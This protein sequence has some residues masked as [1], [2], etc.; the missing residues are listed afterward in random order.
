[1]SGLKRFTGG[2]VERAGPAGPR[3]GCGG[4]GPAGGPGEP[5]PGVTGSSPSPP[6]RAT[7][8]HVRQ[9]RHGWDREIWQVQIE[10]DRDAREKP[11]AFKRKWVR[12]GGGEEQARREGVRQGRRETGR[13]GGRKGWREGGGRRQRGAAGGSRGCGWC[14]VGRGYT[15]VSVLDTENLN[16]PPSTT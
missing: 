8:Q 9:T 3:A 2:E 15:A 14:G 6:C 16:P 11:A 13:E 1:M 4:R 7:C 5:S 12:A 10:E